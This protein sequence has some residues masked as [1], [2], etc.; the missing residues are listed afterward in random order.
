MRLISS[1]RALRTLPQTPVFL[2]LVLR[3]VDQAQALRATDGADGWCVLETLC[4]LNDYEGVFLSRMKRVLDEEN[5]RFEAADHLAWVEEHH[6]KEQ[7]LSDV[8]EQYLS[9]RREM[10]ALLKSL[11]EEAWERNGVYA[12]GT[13]ANLAELAVNACL[14][15]INHIEQIS[16]S[17]GLTG[18]VVP[19]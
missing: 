19:K 14:H 9:R 17:L 4:H 13:E 8:F 15:D 2:E 12:D 16:R 1:V 11:P 7:V 18:Y 10:I 6:Y 5:P 3:G